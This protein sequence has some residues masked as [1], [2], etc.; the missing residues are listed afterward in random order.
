MGLS[1]R[2]VIAKR[3]VADRALLLS[4][5]IATTI[6]TALSAGALL[7]LDALE[8]LAFQDALDRLDT[9][10]P[11]IP[12]VAFRVPVDREAL[13]STAASVSRAIDDTLSSVYVGQ[14][15]SLKVEPYFVG[16]PSR[17]LPAEPGTRVPVSRGYFQHLSNLGANA[18]LVHGRMAED[19]V[20]EGPTEPVVEAVIGRP[21]F[22]SGWF[23]LSVGDMLTVSR[24]LGDAGKISVRIVGV[25]EPRAD[26]VAYWD[27]A[28]VFFDPA[29]LEDGPPP[30]ITVVADEPP[31][32]LFVGRSALVATISDAYPNTLI[33]P[34]SLVVTDKERLAG[35]SVDEVETM[36]ADFETEIVR[37]LPGSIVAHG[38]LEGI[39][40]DIQRRRFFASVPSLLLLTVTITTVVFCLAMMV[41]YLIR[42]RERDV[43]LLRTRGAGSRQLVRLSILESG[44][45]VALATVLG[46]VLAVALV[47]LAGALPLFSGVGDGRSLGMELALLPFA[48]AAGAGLVCFLVL[49]LPTAVSTA[50][51][52]LVQKLNAS[53]PPTLGTIH[54]YNLDVA[55]L[56]LG[57]LVYWEL[58][59][60]GRLVSGGLFGNVEINEAL[61]IAPVLFLLTVA[62]V[63]MRLFPMAMRFV[64]GESPGLLHLV[65]VVSI[66]SLAAILGVGALGDREVLPSL[67]P[68]AALGGLAVFYRATFSTTRVSYTFLGLA[69]QTML[70]GAVLYLEYPDADGLA[71]VPIAGIVTVVPGQLAFA[72]FKGSVRTAPVW[73]SIG[74]WR[75]ARNPLQYTWLV[76]LLVLVTGVSILSTTVGGTLEASQNDSVNYETAG[77]IHV[78]SIPR[79]Y[80]GGPDALR[81]RIVETAGVGGASMAWR[82]TGAVGHSAINV[83]AVE[84]AAFGD[85]AW[86]RDDFSERTLAGVMNALEGLGS[87]RGIPIPDGA[88]GLGVWVKPLERYPSISALMV[89]RDRRDK[90]AVLTLDKFETA[91]WQQMSNDLPFGVEPPLE[92]V[93][94]QIFE[95]GQFAPG[96]PGTVLLDDVYAVMES[97]EARVFEDF[98]AGF[99]WATFATP[100]L[101]T[102]DVYQTA[103]DIYSGKRSAVF[104]FGASKNNSLRG[105]FPS[106]TGGMLPAAVSWSFAAWTGLEL[107]DTFVL[108]MTRRQVRIVI[109]EMVQHFPTMSADGQGFVVMDLDRLLERLNLM[110]V[111]TPVSPSEVFI[112]RTPDAG[113]EVDALLADLTSLTAR[114]DDGRPRLERL[115]SSPLGASGWRALIFVSLGTVLLAAAFGYVTYLR[116]QSDRS[117]HETAFMA[118][119]G[120]SR[121]QFMALLGVEHLGMALAGVGLGTWAGFQMSELMVGSLAVTE[122]GGEVV[123][124]FV[125][126]T[127]WGLMLPT[128]LAIL[129]IVLVSLVVLD[130]RARRADVRMIGRM[131]DF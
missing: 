17:P 90:L 109:E 116:T 73:L 13:D 54:R 33:D 99:D 60:R 21:S 11:G 24:G 23:D 88:T 84:S 96:T 47:T 28:D 80:P 19:R 42:S 49:L 35:L 74:M 94:F 121:R 40:K 104:S 61:L 20:T 58:Q 86:F 51:G 117:R 130:G 65:T 108:T 100:G 93:A 110:D 105:I 125:L 72:A 103:H 85:I 131:A 111:H 118:S 22:E 31:L 126:S 97:G 69:L 53:R 45:V 70:V 34:I 52:A 76:L 15:L 91:E 107:G 8:R 46:S 129:A 27:F 56:T 122:T 50:G 67:T 12:V 55:V 120:M 92:L 95:S 14:E 64:A 106:A 124:P 3:V 30:G 43:G 71:V 7:Y 5:A 25:Y 63:F 78:T 9:P 123:P 79:L 32:P 113:E 115:R 44:L 38:T 6:I 48:L 112:G 18:R 4:V 75:M 98:E 128:Y 2:G 77:D 114:V 10:S 29:P 81:K 59:A 87:V 16:L 82:T 119:L 39:V 66:V 89:L 102:D 41:F 57:G 83:L 62:L 37:A 1:R 36:L 101:E 127:D 26:A 68:L